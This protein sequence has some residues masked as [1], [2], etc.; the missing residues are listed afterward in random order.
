MFERSRL[1]T[2]GQPRP[3]RVRDAARS[4]TR[5]P[6]RGAPMESGGGDALFNE[7]RQECRLRHGVATR[8]APWPDDPYGWGR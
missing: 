7:L 2:L 8:R 1:F 6:A 5:S 3:A 4:P